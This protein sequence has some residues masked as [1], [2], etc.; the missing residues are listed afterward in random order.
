MFCASPQVRCCKFK[1]N[2]EAAET[3]INLHSTVLDLNLGSFC[4]VRLALVAVP[5][6][7]LLVELKC[8][9]TLAARR[10]TVGALPA[11]LIELERN[12]VCLA[13]GVGVSN[14]V[15]SFFLFVLAAS[16]AP[17]P[18][19]VL[20]NW[21]VAPITGE[22]WTLRADPV[23]HGHLPASVADLD[24]RFGR[25]FFSRVLFFERGSTRMPNKLK[26]TFSNNHKQIST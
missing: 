1:I 18:L 25:H 5:L 23:D 10:S 22:C 7:L 24:L 3:R 2:F 9:T 19:F 20:G 16:A 6:F 14:V 13:K 15:V 21:L 12:V 8:T 17:L 26:A 4:L 11:R